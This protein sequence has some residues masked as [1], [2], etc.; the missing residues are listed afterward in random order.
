MCIQRIASTGALAIS[1]V[2]SS[3]CSWAFTAGSARKRGTRRG[4]RRPQPQP[5]CQLNGEEATIVYDGCSLTGKAQLTTGADGLP[6]ARLPPAV[7]P[8]CASARQ[9]RRRPLAQLEV[10]PPQAL[11]SVLMLYY[12][13]HHAA[14]FNQTCTVVS[15]FRALVPKCVVAWGPLARGMYL[16]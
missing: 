2:S 3:G 16:P 6:S 1:S 15:R 14:V 7:A 5:I 10:P 4:R 12:L 13:E 11:V 9:N 8:T